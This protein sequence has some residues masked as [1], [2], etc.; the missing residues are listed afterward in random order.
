MHFHDLESDKAS[1]GDA[2]CKNCLAH[3]DWILFRSFRYFEFCVNQIIAFRHNTMWFFFIKLSREHERPIKFLFG[4]L[5]LIISILI[6][7]N[8]AL[9][10]VAV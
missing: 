5:L 10:W 1:W 4:I 9:N 7:E 3:W 6:D 8:M 2:I